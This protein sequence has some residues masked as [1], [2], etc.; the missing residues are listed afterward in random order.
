MAKKNENILQEEYKNLSFE[1]QK[2]IFQKILMN[3]GRL[4]RNMI[5]FW[6]KPKMRLREISIGNKMHKSMQDNFLHNELGI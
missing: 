3:L 5:D 6:S 2:I 1:E 4:L